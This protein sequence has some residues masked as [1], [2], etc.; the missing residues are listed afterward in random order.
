M[1][2]VELYG[3]VP[4]EQPILEWNRLVDQV[5]LEPTISSLTPSLR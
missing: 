2:R 4:A 1:P 3:S 5:G